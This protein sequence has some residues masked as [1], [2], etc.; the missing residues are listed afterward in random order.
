M[1][2][3][4]AYT[5]PARGHLYPIV[6]ILLE[7]QRRGHEIGLRTLASQ[8]E[9]RARWASTSEQYRSASNKSSWTT[10]RRA[11]SRPKANALWR[12]SSRAQRTRRL[13]SHERSPITT[14]TFSW[15]TS[16]AGAPRLWPRLLDVLGRCTRHTCCRCLRAT[17]R[18]MDWDWPPWTVWSAECVTR[19]SAVWQA[20]S[21][22]GRPC[23]R[24]PRCA[25]ST[26]CPCSIVSATCSDARRCCCCSRPKA[27]SIRA[28]TGR[29]TCAWSAR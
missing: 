28:A 12:L 3:L 2:R 25:P 16:A 1:A 8:V 20:P 6:P 27:L 23:G 11:R 22:T 29:R 14:R 5:S 19:S 26:A 10:T 24:W 18:R 21:S 15:S 13:T 7:L 9:P 17:S 4:L